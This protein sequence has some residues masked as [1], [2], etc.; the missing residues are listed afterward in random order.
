MSKLLT[1][2]GASGKQG[3]SVIQAVLADS[4]LSKD[5]KIRAVTR[6]VSKASAQALTKQGVEVITVSHSS[7]SVILA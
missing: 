1:I 3:G 4:A 2:F 7:T 5:F 6:D